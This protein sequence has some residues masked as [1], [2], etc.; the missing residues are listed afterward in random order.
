VTVGNNDVPCAY[1]SPGCGSNGEEGFS[2]GPGY[3]S[4]NGFGSVDV[5]K[6]IQQWSSGAPTGPVVVASLDQNPVYQG[7]SE[8]CGNSSAWNFQITLTEEAGFATSVTSFSINGADYTPQ[9]KSIFGTS[10]IGAR[11]SISGCMSIASVNAPTYEAFTLSGTPNW[12]TALNISFQGPQTQLNVGGAANA[13]SYVQSYAP[14]MIMAVFGTGFGTLSQAAATLPLPSYMAGFGATICPVSCQT[15]S[16]GYPVY[17]YYVGPNQVNL[18]VPY[19]FTGAADL[20]LGNPY[21]NTD[22]FFTISSAAPGI[23]MLEDG[24]QNV[25]P[26]QTLS[27]GQTGTVYVTGVG[28]VTPQPPDGDAPS[29]RAPQ[30]RQ[31]VTVTVGGIA[32]QTTYD[33][34]PD[35]SVGVLQINFTVPSGAPAGRQ[36]V[37]VTIGTTPSPAAY[38]TIQ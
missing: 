15:A 25:N 19:E 21:Q 9:I 16:V 20:Y 23:F 17:L 8:S 36:P 38:I 10:E 1:G 28:R 13:A 18:Q 4:A 7:N 2:A 6:L 27:V 3:N 35:W 29:G 32:A 26:A 11:Q 34:I 30:P 22:F 5:T 37:V 31:A 12:S 24:S 33:A 14:G